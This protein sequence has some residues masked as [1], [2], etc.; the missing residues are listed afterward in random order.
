MPWVA[1]HQ[2]SSSP[3][4][5]VREGPCLLGTDSPC[6]PR[7]ADQYGARAALSLSFVAA[8]ALY[9]LLAASCSPALPGVFLLFASRLPSALMHTLTGRDWWVDP[10]E[11]GERGEMRAWLQVGGRWRVSGME[12]VHG[13]RQARQSGEVCR[14]VD[15]VKG[16]VEGLWVGEY[17]LGG[18]A[19]RP[20][21]DT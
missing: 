4:W 12:M 10:A 21:L 16:A 9:L 18:G 17:N 19:A 15:W 3:K 2:L 5:G 6:C 7:F 1:L 14:G 13:L 11:R 20:G 8:S